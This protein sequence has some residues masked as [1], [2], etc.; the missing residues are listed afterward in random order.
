MKKLI[1]LISL[2]SMAFISMA[3]ISCEKIQSDFADYM[4]TFEIKGPGVVPYETITK[5][6]IYE[7]VIGHGWEAVQVC[8]FDSGKNIV[9]IHEVAGDQKRDC[10]EVKGLGR[11]QVMEYLLEYEMFRKEE[12]SYDENYNSISLPPLWYGGNLVYLSEDIMVCIDHESWYR[13]FVFRKVKPS[14]LKEWKNKCPDED[15]PV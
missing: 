6:D 8:E 13:M 1:C 12:F 10:F 3:F 7:Y 2:I 4:D 9:E 5:A 11:D 15:I 14:V